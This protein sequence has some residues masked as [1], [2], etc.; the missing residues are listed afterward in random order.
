MTSTD[1]QKTSR[2]GPMEVEDWVAV[3]WG[4]V[5]AQFSIRFASGIVIREF[6]IV[7]SGDRRWIGL[8]QRSYKD[9][10]GERQYVDLAKFDSRQAYEDFQREALAAV[11]CFLAETGQ[12]AP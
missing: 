1:T 2:F 5:R 3:D 11:N 10:W 7:K 8:P 9:E 6:C 12:D 4:A